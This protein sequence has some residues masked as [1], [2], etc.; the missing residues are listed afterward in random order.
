MSTPPQEE[1]KVSG[2]CPFG[3]TNPE[4]KGVTGAPDSQRLSQHRQDYWRNLNEH[5]DENHQEVKGR[6]RA[7]ILGNADV[8][9]GRLLK[10]DEAE[11][12]EINK[13]RKIPKKKERPYR[14]APRVSKEEEDPSKENEPLRVATTLLKPGPDLSPDGKRF[15]TT[16]NFIEVEPNIWTPY[17]PKYS[18]SESE[19]SSDHATD[20]EERSLPHRFA[21]QAAYHAR[22]R[23]VQDQA[24]R[25]FLQ[26]LRSIREI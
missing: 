17:I 8:G 15:D 3:C 9:M 5:L 22:R 18:A 19:E 10:E 4:L 11:E 21:A 26:H 1:K 6:D 16:K 23:A 7:E 12:A 14:L 25:S 2:V 20:N 24:H 13:H